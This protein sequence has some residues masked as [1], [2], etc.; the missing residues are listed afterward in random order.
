VDKYK[1]FKESLKDAAKI[2]K[3]IENKTIRIV[4][5]LDCDGIC[6]C[7]ILIKALNNENRKYSVSI[8]QQLNKQVIEELSNENNECI[9][10]SD[11]GSGQLSNINCFLN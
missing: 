4:S 6:A 3:K 8:V 10:F 9:I 11:L 2:F 5:H 1:Q 7:S